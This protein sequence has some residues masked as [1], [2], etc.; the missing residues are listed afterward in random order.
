[1]FQF[2]HHQSLLIR[3]LVLLFF[4]GITNTLYAQRNVILIIADDIGT[5]YFGCYENHKDTI[6][7]PNLNRLLNK[8]VRFKNATA[9]PICS[10]TRAGI[11]TGRYC[12]RT[13][14][15]TSVGDGNAN[16]TP[17]DTNE[18]SLPRLMR[19]NFQNQIKMAH[20]G[21]WHLHQD[22]PATAMLIPNKMGY[23]FYSGNFKALV[24]NY[25]HWKK[26][27]NGSYQ[28]INNYATVET[29]ND[30][31]SWIKSQST[32][33][34]FLWV[35]YNAP[36]EPYHYAPTNLHS[37][38]NLSGTPQDINNNPKPYFMA[39]L[40]ALD[41][42]M[43]RLLD[44]LETLQLM[45]S[46]D[47][48]FIGD[49]GSP[50]EVAQNLD[51]LLSKGTIYEN[52][53]QV[54]FVISG[55][56]VVNPGRSSDALVNTVD[57][58]ATVLELFG[59]NN[60]QSYIYPNKPVDTKSIMPIIKNQAQQIR[61]WNFT[62]MFNSKSKANDGKAIKNG[63][64]KLLHFNK[65]KREFYYLPNDSDE[66]NN[67]L[68]TT[69]TDSDFVNYQYLCNEMATLLD[70]GYALC[71]AMID[72]SVVIS[73]IT[74]YGQTTQITP[75]I[76]GAVAPYTYLWSN[77]SSQQNLTNVTA[78]TYTL[79]VTDN[80]GQN[81]Q[82][83]YHV[84]Q[85]DSL[86]ATD[87]IW[88]CN[89]AA[90]SMVTGGVKPYTYL[91]DNGNTTGAQYN[92]SAGVYTVTITD[93]NGCTLSNS[94]SIQTIPLLE[95]TGNATNVLCNGFN[96]GSVQTTI[97][98]GKWPYNYLWS[99]GLTTKDA[100]N[101]TNATY[102][103]TVTD[104][105]GCKKTTD[106]II[107]E[108]QPETCFFSFTAPECDKFCDGAAQVLS[109]NTLNGYSF[110]WSNSAT[111][112]SI[113]NICA[114]LYTVTISNTN[115][116]TAS[117][118]AEI[119]GKNLLQFTANVLPANCPKTKTGRANLI[120][121]NGHSPF[122]YLWNNIPNGVFSN[123]LISG[124]HNI[125]VIDGHG[126]RYDSTIFIPYL[127]APKIIV[128]VTAVTCNSNQG[129]LLATASNGIP[130]YS[131]LWSNGNTT[132]G[133]SQLSGGTYLVTVTDS[134][135]CKKTL[136]TQLADTGVVPD[137]PQPI[138]GQNN[139]VCAGTN[140][141]LYQINPVANSIGYHWVIPV[142]STLVSGQGTTSIVLNYDSNFVSGTLYAQAFN[143]CG[144]GQQRF[145]TIRS[146]PAV[147]SSI[148]GPVSVCANQNNVL[149]EILPVPNA[150]SYQWLKPANTQIVSGRG[151]TN[152]LLNFQN[153]G[154]K[155][156]VMATNVC[157]NSDAKSL[158]VNMNCRNGS[159]QA[160]EIIIMP[161]PANDIVQVSFVSEQITAYQIEIFDLMGHVLKGQSKMAEI[162]DNQCNILLA[163]IS[164]GI[165]FVKISIGNE[166]LISKLVI[167]K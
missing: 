83:T 117:A 116:C 153:N 76:T 19:L 140:N 22:T 90:R 152:V 68:K 110:L 64:Y 86:T 92:L 126:C 146:V 118:T 73:P 145:L 10:P 95:V 133:I 119:K 97:T 148:I 131:Y 87:S 114:G 91:W 57:I 33:P 96:N 136:V 71:N 17:L 134:L 15:G 93:Q 102:T 127:S 143:Q 42:E 163:D 158:T 108:T 138:A 139:T 115:N 141:V 104:A 105:V 75:T 67:L 89:K 45:D 137:K 27:T 43:G 54:P 66:T 1:M 16:A 30:A 121:T 51:S 120:V 142:N 144:M 132:A 113:Q 11:F 47:I 26:I 13:G 63:S 29:T 52:G 32:N 159:L 18:L 58:F 112:Q 31:V 122:T 135:K 164:A 98:G 3:K 23:D 99:N 160:S 37:F 84:T 74:C 157:G 55:P 80:V 48:I 62:E 100:F 77:G 154:G 130:P 12:F 94:I 147:P 61:P 34:F 103:L 161:N 39:A 123:R 2:A 14:V 111:T 88:N 6:N 38:P 40:E 7:A 70:S 69:V 60:W 85:P 167:E 59:F 35:S 36:H 28:M 21:K 79:T 9:N 109:D 8:G 5:D 46:T 150:S 128:T 156:K 125:S 72:A 56:S 20:I 162:G 165:Y 166:T 49:N 155:V 149:Y 106:F 151:T 53:V 78:G 82:F 50:N 107:I 65:G 4:L 41:T 24:N 129:A 124:F 44:S 101:L 25:Y 81:R